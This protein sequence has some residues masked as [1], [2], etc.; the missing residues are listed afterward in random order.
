MPPDDSPVL[1]DV[2]RLIWR[3]WRGQ[4]PTGIDRACLAYIDHYR[5]RALAVIQRG[6]FTRVLG[7]A[8]SGAL[9]DLLLRPRQRNFR[10]DMLRVLARAMLPG[11]SPARKRIENLAYI[12]VG[13]TG[14]ERA[15][16]GRWVH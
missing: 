3:G 10:A 13:H 4:L 12:N 11:R 16:H 9:F 2:S 8:D 14:L 6:G 7:K 5:R 1:L 15:G